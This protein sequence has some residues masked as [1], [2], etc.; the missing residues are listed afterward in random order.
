MATT[1]LTQTK[2]ICI[3]I[4]QPHPYLP[5]MVENMQPGSPFLKHLHHPVNSTDALNKAPMYDII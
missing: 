1:D 4:A 5:A 2:L 3:T